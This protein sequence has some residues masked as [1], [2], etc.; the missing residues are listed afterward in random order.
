MNRRSPSAPST[1]GERTR[2]AAALRVDRLS[3]GYGDIKVLREVTFT[4]GKGETLAIVGRNGAGK[5]T[6]LGAIAGIVGVTG[7]VVE[8]VGQNLLRHTPYERV[9]MGLGFVQEGRQIFRK[10]TVEQNLVIGGFAC[11]LSRAELGRRIER[12]YERFP[13]LKARRKN[14]SG[15]L[16][17][18]QQ[19]MLAISRVLIGEPKVLMLDEPSAG[20][21]RPVVAEMFSHV[22]LLRRDGISIIIVEQTVDAVCELADNLILLEVGR[23]AGS[24][25]GRTPDSAKKARDILFRDML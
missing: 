11:K 12:E 13:I 23:V 18:G 21:A 5:T 6:L 24:V 1:S 17:G 16:S 7:G 3:A 25:Q 15:S 4:V 8:L 14:A 19:Q 10:R 9:R 2:D 22:E 20:L